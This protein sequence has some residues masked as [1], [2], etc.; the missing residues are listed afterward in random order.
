[1]CSGV[2]QAGIASHVVSSAPSGVL[3]IVMSVYGRYAGP[4]FA[5]LDEDVKVWAVYCRAQMKKENVWAAVVTRGF[6]IINRKKRRSVSS[7]I[8]LAATCYVHQAFHEEPEP[9]V[10]FPA[11]SSVLLSHRMA[12]RFQRIYL[13]I[14]GYIPD[15]AAK[16]GFSKALVVTDRP[17]SGSGLKSDVTAEAWDLMN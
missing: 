4:R 11:A 14:S 8:L 3:V 5:Q 7:G 16:P 1:V 15:S 6:G 9:E 13:D 2:G 17:A 12:R 10:S